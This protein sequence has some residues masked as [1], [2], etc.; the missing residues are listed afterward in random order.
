MFP[1]TWDLESRQLP[2]I[3]K[4]SWR[5]HQ[6]SSHGVWVASVGFLQTILLATSLL[7]S[8]KLNQGKSSRWAWWPS[9]ERL[10]LSTLVD[11]CNGLIPLGVRSCK[12]RRRSAA[13]WT[14]AWTSRIIFCC[15]ACLKAVLSRPAS[16]DQRSRRIRLGLVQF[17]SQLHA[18]FLYVPGLKSWGSVLV[19]MNITAAQKGVAD[20]IPQFQ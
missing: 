12:R 5:S 3:P 16:P 2:W 17:P 7:T 20:F 15:A 8:A 4:F 6:R 10:G 11:V 13:L 1:E 19:Q 18:L 14:A 9:Y